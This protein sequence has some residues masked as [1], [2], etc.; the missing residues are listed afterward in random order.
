MLQ[1]VPRVSQDM[2]RNFADHSEHSSYFKLHK[3]LR[4]PSIHEK[5]RAHLLQNAFNDPKK[6]PKKQAKLSRLIYQLINSDD[7]NASLDS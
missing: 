5:N 2:A 4:D 1:Q 3:L 6:K 7:H